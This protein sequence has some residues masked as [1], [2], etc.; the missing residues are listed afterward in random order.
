M[1]KFGGLAIALILLVSLAGPLPSAQAQ[2]NPVNL[3][4]GGEGATSWN[5]VNIIPGD[6]GTKTLT[7]HNAGGVDG[8]VTI[9]VS[10]IISSEGINPESETGNTGEP[11]E[12]DQYLLLNISCADLDSNISLPAT[13]DNLPH[14]ASD[15]HYIKISPL[16]VGDT[17][18]LDWQ[19]Q[20]PVEAGNEVQGDSLSF[21]IN[22]MLEEFGEDE[23]ED[24][25]KDEDEG[26]PPGTTDVSGMVSDTC[27]F[28]GSLTII[29]EDGLCRLYI[30]EGTVG[31]TWE[32]EC[33]SEITIVIMDEP[34]PPPENGQVI[35]LVYDFQPSGAT[36]EPP[37]T[38]E[39]S[40]DP[41]NIPEGIAEKNLV[42]AYYDEKAGEWVELPCTVDPVTNTITASVSHFTAFGAVFIPAP[43]N[44][45]LSQLVISPTEVD[46]G[47]TVNV[48][49]SVANTGGMVGSYKVPLKVNGVVVATKDITLSAGT[50]FEVT[51]TT[52]KDVAGSYSVDVNGLTGSF[53][54]KDKPAPAPAPTPPPTTI[55]EKPFPWPLV[56]IIAGVVAAGLLGFFL[57]RRSRR[58]LTT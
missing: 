23:D 44:F 47:E 5:I 25:D 49:I 30:P 11:G 7:L 58:T 17:I 37:V 36:L 32:L 10:D 13:I 52:A 54:V 51:F 41:D 55:P 29:S 39:Y 40:Y 38:L 6:S 57:V 35:G 43:A 28:L 19:W 20:L 27:R 2:D 34:P 50:T 1:T 9:W 26:P 18:T 8:F 12:L 31:L 3:E 16:N 45:I 4:L 24:K 48:T 46:A 56:G 53:T 14:S 42:I 21:T 15:P 22:Y 33:V